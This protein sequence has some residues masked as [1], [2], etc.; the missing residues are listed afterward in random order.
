M[1]VGWLIRLGQP[2]GRGGSSPADIAVHKQLLDEVLFGFGQSEE[3]PD[4]VGQLRDRVHL[5]GPGW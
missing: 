5:R 3:M 2:Y 4:D 1:H